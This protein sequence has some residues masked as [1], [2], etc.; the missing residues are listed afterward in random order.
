MKNPETLSDPVIDVGSDYLRSRSEQVQNG[1]L[2]RHI[3]ALFKNAQVGEITVVVKGRAPIVH[4]GMYPGSKVTLEICNWRAV[5]KYLTSGE[6]GFADAFISG[7]LNIDSPGNL[8][9]WYLA[10]EEA[11]V[12]TP[13]ATWLTGLWNRFTHKFLNNNNRSGSR[14]NISYHYDLGNDFYREW[15]DPTMSYSSGDFS[16]TTCLEQSQHAKYARICD[17]IDIQS[18]DRVLEIGC[19]WGGFAEHVVSRYGAEYKGITISREQ[20][21]Y[22]QKRLE[23]EPSADLVFEDY[24]DTQ[25]K[26]D[27]IVSIEMFEAVGENHWPTYFE[28]LKERLAENG[29][30]S[31][32]VITIDHDRFLKYRDKVDFIQKYIFPGG[33]L[34]SKEAFRE[35]ANAAGLTVTDCFAFGPDYAETLRRWRESFITSWPRLQQQGFDDRFYRMWLYYLEYCEAGFDAGTID[36]VQ[37]SLR[38]QD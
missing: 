38:H 27:K 4:R 13:S 17:A 24:R 22:A 11:V 12:N 32:Q 2:A 19:G 7:D 14:K 18:G 6:L 21:A 33:M 3:K 15:L 16:K 8:F 25:G 10:N 37:F 20:L 28:T 31:I 36:V 26:F 5:W 1:F 34:P 23:N 29:R 30:A 9:S 35:H